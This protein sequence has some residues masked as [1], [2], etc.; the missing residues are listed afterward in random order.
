LLLR[1]EL[2]FRSIFFLDFERTS[3]CTRDHTSR[4]HF[5]KY[6]C[7]AIPTTLWDE[8]PP[9]PPGIHHIDNA[10]TLL[11]P[12]ASKYCSYWPSLLTLLWYIECN[13]HLDGFFPVDID[14]GARW[15]DFI[16]QNTSTSISEEP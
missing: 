2:K 1:N 15:R 10:I 12:S 5:D 14:S 4:R 7:K 11:P 13:V 16:T 3:I 6:E 8:L 9:A